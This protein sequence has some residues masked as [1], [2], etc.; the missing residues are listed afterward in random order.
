MP[1]Y[2]YTC[3]A[4]GHVT[5]V[6][7][8]IYE[9]GPRFCP[10]CGAEGTMSKKLVAPAVVFKGSGWAKKDRSGAKAASRSASDDGG[11]SEPKAKPDDSGGAGGSDDASASKGSKG[12]KGDASGTPPKTPAGSD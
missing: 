2:D 12:S 4:C 11:D 9:H 10:E 5:E 8:G 1:V 3:S 7:H 6:L